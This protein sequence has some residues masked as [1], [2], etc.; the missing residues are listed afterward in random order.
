VRD[1][2]NFAMGGQR[3]AL[4]TSRML[5]LLLA[6]CIEIVG[7]AAGRISDREMRYERTRRE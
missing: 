6:K 1:A 3:D 5:T 7:E 4:D 2:V